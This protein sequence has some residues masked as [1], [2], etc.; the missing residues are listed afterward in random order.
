MHISNVGVVVC[1]VLT[2]GLLSEKDD[3]Q[4]GPFKDGSYHASSVRSIRRNKQ[5]VRSIRPGE[6]ASVALVLDKKSEES[7]RRGM[8]LLDAKEAGT[9]CWRFAARLCLLCH[10]ASE[11]GVN[12]QGTVYIGSVCQTVQVVDLDE[13]PEVPCRWVTVQFRF[14]ISPEYVRTGTPLIF[15]Q[16]KTKGIGEVMQI[17]TTDL[18][19]QEVDVV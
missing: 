10:P 2:E 7:I 16:S 6:A 12:F 1:G 3:V 19:T 18:K 4:I 9:A 14:L 17:F 8:V 13:Q 15:R 11:L 5:P